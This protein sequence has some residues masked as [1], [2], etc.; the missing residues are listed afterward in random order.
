MI[1][2]STKSMRV[3]LVAIRE[4]R[5]GLN[6]HREGLLRRV[7][8]SGDWG[9]FQLESIMMKDIAYLTAYTGHEFAILRGKKED[10][11]VHGEATRC[12]FDDVLVDMLKNRRLIIY[13]HSHPGEEIPIPSSGDRETLRQI[14]Q[15]ESRLISGYS[16]V[17]VVFTSDPFEIN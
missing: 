7:P 9:K 15:R 13:G 1:L 17:E 14:G 5:D 4:G 12:R 11:L 3:S 6:S 2:E 8:T 16:G 10:I